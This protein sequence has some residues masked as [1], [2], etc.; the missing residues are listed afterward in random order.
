[1]RS[2]GMDSFPGIIA[3]NNVVEIE[4]L[5]MNK[6]GGNLFTMPQWP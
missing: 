5:W 4:E 1:M 2:A 3:L 6:N